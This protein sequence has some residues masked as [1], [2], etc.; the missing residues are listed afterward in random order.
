MSRRAPFFSR[1]D[2]VEYRWY[3]PDRKVLGKTM[4]RQLRFAVCWWHSFVG[5]GLDPFGGDTFRRPWHSEGGDPMEQARHKVD[6]AFELF[7]LLRTRYFTFHDLDL[8]PEGTTLRETISNVRRIGD[9]VGERMEKAR[10]RPLWGMAN[11][12]SNR[13]YMAG[14]ATNPDPAVFA[15]AAAQSKNALELSRDLRAEGYALWGGREGYETLLNTD[16]SRELD[17]LGRFLNLIVEHKHRIGFQG[18]ILVETKP[19]EP[20]KHLYDADVA[21]V[22]GFLERYGLEREVKINIEQNHALMAGHTFEHEI[23]M[24]QALGVFG[25][26]DMN[27]GDE[28][29]G[30]DTVHFPNNLPHVALALYTILKGGG[31]PRGGGI[32]FD[33]KIR[34]QSIDPDDLL[35]AHAEAIDLCARALI[36][37]EKMVKDDRLGEA[38]AERYAGWDGKLGRRILRGR[39]SLAELAAYVDKNT[40]EPQPRSGRQERLE[41]LV[42]SYL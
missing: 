10:V 36:V 3:E 27:R 31:F 13:R 7:G 20:A 32:N 18:A 17:Q 35:F 2:P 16:V 21:A 8:A 28:L 19:A 29:L 40:L 23:A 6:V 4:E 37:A 22:Y 25:S 41:A 24:A 14:A 38:L 33:A 5:R 11:L 1:T 26:V 39:K 34:R 15:Y 12:T 42:N 30:W 9:L